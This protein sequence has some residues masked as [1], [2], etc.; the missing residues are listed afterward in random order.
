MNSKSVIKSSVYTD[1]KTTLSMDTPPVNRGGR[2]LVPLRFL[3]ESEG[4]VTTWNAD[5]RT[6]VVRDPVEEAKNKSAEA[7]NQK[8]N[9]M[10]GAWECE[11][12]ILSIAPSVREK[13]KLQAQFYYNNGDGFYS[14][15]LI[16]PIYGKHTLKQLDYDKVT[17]TMDIQGETVM[18]VGDKNFS[19]TY[20]NK[21]T[22][23]K[24]GNKPDPMFIEQ[25]LDQ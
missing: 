8:Y 20:G 9:G 19:K 13:G 21:M 23:K 25:A 3:V 7:D 24:T 10:I 17:I 18:V 14:E 6:V 2:I 12:W 1:E 22:L 15:G 11:T 4:L 16:E 5:T